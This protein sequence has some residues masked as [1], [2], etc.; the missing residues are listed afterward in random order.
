MENLDGTVIATA[1][2]R[3][4]ESFRISPCWPVGRPAQYGETASLAVNFLYQMA[5]AGRA[6]S[7]GFPRCICSRRDRGFG[8]GSRFSGS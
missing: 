8:L 2:P 6:G 4:S 3:M 5:G 1:L 7:G